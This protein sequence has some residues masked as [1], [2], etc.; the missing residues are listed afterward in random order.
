[1]WKIINSITG[2]TNSKYDLVDYLK[3]KN[4]EIHNRDEIA[5]EFAKHFSKVGA[6]FANK[7]LTPKRTSTDYLSNI[8]SSNTSLFLAPTIPQKFSI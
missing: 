4:V 1:M 3:I 5:T 8:P 6:C 7:I 2:K